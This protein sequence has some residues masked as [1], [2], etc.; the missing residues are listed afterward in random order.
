MRKTLLLLAA[1]LL[2]CAGCRARQTPAPAAEPAVTAAPEA[3][4][5]S[6]PAET[7]PAPETQPPEAS[8]EQPAETESAPQPAETE[9]A[10]AETA[11]EPAGTGVD[12]SIALPQA[13]GTMQVS[14][15]P[16]DP[17]IRVVREQRGI[18]ASLLAA[19]FTVP[20]NGQNYVF[21]FTGAERTAETIRRVY[22]IDDSGRIVS[23]A[24]ADGAERENVS[25][26]ENWFCMNV[27]IRG[28]VFPAVKDA[29]SA[30]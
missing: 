22:L 5:P 24:A 9:P 26:A 2:L 11:A 21:E 18:E 12:L 27:L 15:D 19:V 25:A 28:V 10:P 1:V 7:E 30:E 29:L 13:N 3:Q 17:Y 14:T 16:E 23:V 6:A 20:Q 4:L 8:S